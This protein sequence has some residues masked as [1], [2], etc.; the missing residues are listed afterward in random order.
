[1]LTCPP[2]IVYEM[3]VDGPEREEHLD[4]T[5]A[6][7]GL[8]TPDVAPRVLDLPVGLLGPVFGQ[9]VVVELPQCRLALFLRVNGP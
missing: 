3:C 5:L 1:M 4:P 7:V 6:S 9:V 8:P 2:T